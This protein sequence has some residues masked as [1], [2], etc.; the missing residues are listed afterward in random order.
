MSR[1]GIF[2]WLALPVLALVAANARAACAPSC[3]TTTASGAISSTI[4]GPVTVAMVTNL[5]FGTIV[6]PATSAGNGTVS[7]VA[8][9]GSRTVGGTAL[10]LA[11]ASASRAQFTITGEGA[12]SVGVSTPGSISLT[13]GAN[14]LTVTLSRSPSTSPQTLSGSAGSDGTKTIFV[15]GSFPLTN[16]TVPGAYTGSMTLTATYQ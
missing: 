5:A 11:S 8:S 4:M 15:G 14:T 9:S 16:A 7:I 12:S 13:S 6:R 1:K 3:P 10:P 2:V